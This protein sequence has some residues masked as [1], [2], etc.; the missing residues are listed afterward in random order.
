MPAL[1]D[2]NLQGFD[3]PTA[4]P[5]NTEQALGWQEANRSWWEGHPMRYDWRQ[6]ITFEEFTKE[7]YQ[8]IDSRFFLDAE[9]YMPWKKI[10][11]DLLI[12]FD[13]LHEK[14]VLEI[15]TG[16]GSHAGL[17]SQYAR[18]FTGIDIT[19][20]AVRS[21]SRRMQCFGFSASILQMD[22]ERM[23]F[24]DNSFDLIWTWGVIHHTADTSRV[25]SEMR[26]VLRP[27]GQAIIM[28]YHRNFWNWYIFNGLFRGVLQGEIFR[29]GSLHRMVQRWTDGAIARYYSE[30]EWRKLASQFFHVDSTLVFGSKSEIVPLPAGGVKNTIISLVPNSLSRF[31][32]NRCK[33]GAFLV[34]ILG[35]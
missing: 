2:K 16:N 18:S 23:G 14:D 26:R 15:G 1:K 11:F 33:M 10:P 21:T 25:L 17:I 30:P 31:F 22:A 28:V 19:T 24:E 7:F 13:T 34:S 5:Q 4:V 3:S 27:E 6:E 32:T 35:K 20:Y 29:A 8:E 9:V 12:D